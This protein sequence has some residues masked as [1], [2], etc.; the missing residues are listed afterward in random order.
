[1]YQTS[2]E[3][4]DVVAKHL[5]DQGKKSEKQG[6]WSS[7]TICAYRGDGN[8]KCAIGALLPDEIYDERLEGQTIRSERFE[9]I[10]PLVFGTNISP[11]FLSDLQVLHDNFP[12]SEWKEKLSEYAFVQ[13][14]NSAVVTNHV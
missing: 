10:I 14:L 13:G 8:T 7:G 12:P 5:L 6:R 1:M 3:V 9:R 4:F 2:Q 11:E